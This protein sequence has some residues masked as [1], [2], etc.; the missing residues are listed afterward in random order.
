[1]CCRSGPRRTPLTIVLVT[2]AYNAYKNHKEKRRLEAEQ[3]DETFEKKRDIPEQTL[4]E[5]MHGLRLE[6]SGI[7]PPHYDDVVQIQRT[8]LSAEEPTCTDH[9]KE[10]NK[11]EEDRDSLSDADS[12]LADELFV[13]GQRGSGH[14]E[15]QGRPMSK[16]ERRALRREEKRREWQEWRAEKA[17]RRAARFAEGRERRTGCCGC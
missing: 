7:T 16:C 13:T 3:Y 12:L 11:E 9:S 4:S 14:K 10:A 5:A 6:Q 2:A 8:V 17:A 15:T 1:M